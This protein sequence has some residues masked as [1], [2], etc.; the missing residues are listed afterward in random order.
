MSRFCT[1]FFLRAWL[2]GLSLT[3]AASAAALEVGDPAPDFLLTGSD[4]KQHR[5]SDY[6][7]RYVVIAWFP[8]AFT[9]G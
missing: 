4:G 3:I 9:G 2:L 1:R 6:R 7:G 8:K 5:L